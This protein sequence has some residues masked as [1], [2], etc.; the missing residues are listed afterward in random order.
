MAAIHAYC[1]ECKRET[2]QV[3]NH[4]H[5]ISIC[6]VC[7]RNTVDDDPEDDDSHGDR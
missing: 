5:A 4:V 6:D 7:G 1:A 2:P 3:Y